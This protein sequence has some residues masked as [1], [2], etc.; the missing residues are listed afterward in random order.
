MSS[1]QISL[2]YCLGE[3]GMFWGDCGVESASALCFSTM[4]EDVF[5]ESAMLEVEFAAKQCFSG[6]KERL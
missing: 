6:Q 5:S 1:F 4:T 3:N 2:R